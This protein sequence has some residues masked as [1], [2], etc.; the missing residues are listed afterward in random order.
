MLLQLTFLAAIALATA[1]HG[2]TTPSRAI[3]V[4]S[5]ETIRGNITFTQVQDGKVHVQ[6]GITGLPPGEYGFHVHEKGDL[7]GGCL[8]TGSHFNP[9]HKDHGHPNDVNRHVGDL[10]N[11]V[12]DENHYS[13]IDLVD[14]QISLSGPHG[15]IG[16]AVV[17]HEKAD[18]YGKSDHPDSRKTGNAGGRVACGVI[19]I[20]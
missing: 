10:G 15:I 17:L 8:S 20:L 5:T 12:F 4:L 14:D 7:S 6:G 11:V 19:G 2:F 9:E 3:A 18:D 1:H 13:R 16:R